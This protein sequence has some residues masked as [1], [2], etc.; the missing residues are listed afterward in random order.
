MVYL[1][2]ALCVVI[3]L[4]WA[5]RGRLVRES[6]LD[7]L[8]EGGLKSVLNLRALHLYIYGRWTPQY[9]KVLVT[10]I[11]PLLS[12]KGK[13]KLADSYHSKVLTTELAK[14][15]ITI[16]RQV[17]LCD[18][19]QIITYPVAR[20]IILDYPLDVIAIE[21]ACRSVSPNPCSPSQV[22]MIV[23]KPLTDFAREHRAKFKQL[24][25]QE[26]LD[27]LDDAH[28]KGWVHT[29][30]FKDAVFERFYAICNCCKCCCVGLKL[31]RV[32]GVPNVLSSGYACRKNETLCAHCGICRKACPFEAINESDETV[33]EKCMGCGVCVSMC[34]KSARLLVRD[35]AKG[36]PLDVKA[37]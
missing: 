27:L 8:K 20:K 28:R 32:H 26:G 25:Q 23:G 17:P 29:A 10:R 18:L 3:F 16:N 13:Q 12:R 5:E 14:N 24:T 19:E 9:V 22:C 11:A 1:S 37:L 6:T 2:A 33:Y 15:I 21:C 30:W 4:L 7:G 35:E 31:M 36:I 34:K